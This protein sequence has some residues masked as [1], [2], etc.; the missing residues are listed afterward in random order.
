MGNSAAKGITNSYGTQFATDMNE[1]QV[2][3]SVQQYYGKTLE[4]SKDLKTNACTT[5]GSPHPIIQDCLRKIPTEILEKFYGCGNPIP[6]GIEGLSVLD[7]GSGSG[8]DCYIASQMVGPKGKVIGVDMTDEQLAVAR[9]YTES[10]CQKMGFSAPN[11]DFVQGYIE[12]LSKAGIAKNSVDLVI[13]NCVINLSPR[14]DL[15]LKECYESLKP[16]GEMYF[17]DVY[18]DRRLPQHIREH[19]VLWGECLAGALYIEDF[20]RLCRE[21]GFLD[22]RAL[23]TSLITVNDPELE[24]IL[25]QAKF[26]SILYRLFKTEGLETTNEDIRPSKILLHLIQAIQ[27]G[28]FG[29]N[30]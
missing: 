27:N 12:Q 2:Q 28:R 14:K 29:N 17:S 19:E 26:Y 25:G 1:E 10:F 9:K 11:M 22:P 16:G 6:L 15:V 21:V 8:R 5:S 30:K 13:S 24:K 18:C 4:T 23:S 20:K 7:L 3:E